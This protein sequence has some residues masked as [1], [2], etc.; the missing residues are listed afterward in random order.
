MVDG[1]VNESLN[2]SFVGDVAHRAVAADGV[3]CLPY[4]LFIEVGEH[5]CT[6]PCSEKR[7]GH[8][9][10]DPPAAPGNHRYTAVQFHVEDS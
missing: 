5:H 1:A 3:G 9:L 7:S 2:L 4:S 8:G 10:P 6:R